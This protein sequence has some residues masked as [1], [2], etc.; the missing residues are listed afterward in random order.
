MVGSSLTNSNKRQGFK[1]AMQGVVPQK[2]TFLS[3]GETPQTLKSPTP[4]KKPYTLI[5]PSQRIDLPGNIIVTSVDVEEG[6]WDLGV[7]KVTKKKAKPKNEPKQN[8]DDIPDVVLDYSED[9]GR[10]GGAFDW[11]KVEKEFDGYR[12]AAREDI[13]EGTIL[14]WKVRPRCLHPDPVLFTFAYFAFLGAC[15]EPCNVLP[16]AHDHGR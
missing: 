10:T 16:R 13:V 6:V 4:V 14:L 1:Q 8:I 15:P 3:P 9:G 7:Q 5:P 2:T 12:T 11:V